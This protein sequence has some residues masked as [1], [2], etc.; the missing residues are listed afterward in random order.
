[1][2]DMFIE[3]EEA[4]K[5]E[6]LEKLWQNYGGY[7][8]GFIVL[9]ILGT[10]GFSG[11]KS[12]D[13]GVRTTQT[14][15]FI[16]AQQQE[17]PAQA[18]LDLAPSFRPGLSTIAQLQA[19][20]TMLEGGIEDEALSIYDNVAK[21]E[22]A[23]VEFR[24]LARFTLARLEARNDPDKALEHLTPLMDGSG[25]WRHHARLEAAI[26]LAYDKQDFKSAR[27]QLAALLSA[28]AVPQSLSK[29]ASS[30]DILYALKQQEQENPESMQA[31]QPSAS[32]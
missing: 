11:Y 9:S 4:M 32:K 6:R 26:I 29:K 13:Q 5:Q 17:Y 30:L 27:N 20:G 8:I 31:I 15:Q 12:W 16:D 3:V 25:A 10:A 24:E 28:E 23:P 18:L 22:S 2:A 1:M 7:L 21:D 19:A 14:T